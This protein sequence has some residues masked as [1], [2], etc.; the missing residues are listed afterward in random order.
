MASNSARLRR[1]S[2]QRRL[3]S[4]R[5]GIVTERLQEDFR[6]DARRRADIL[7]S[8]TPEERAALF[9]E[10][11]A[12]HE[13]RTTRRQ[14]EL[15]DMELDRIE[16]RAKSDFFLALSLETGVAWSSGEL[17]PGVVYTRRELWPLFPD[18]PEKWG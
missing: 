2:Q 4:V 11:R 13:E 3:D 15:V 16:E 18:A 14:A 8:G 12:E 9:A 5:D 1:Q 10:Y 7:E 6:T 17:P